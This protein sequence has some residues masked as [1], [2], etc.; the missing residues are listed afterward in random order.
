MSRVL[1]FFKAYQH[2]DAEETSI[3]L[4]E[5][6]ELY[7]SYQIFPKT[8]LAQLNSENYPK[9]SNLIHQM[10]E[11]SRVKTEGGRQYVENMNARTHA[12]YTKLIA[13]LKAFERDTLR[14][15]FNQHSSINL[16]ELQFVVFDLSKMQGLPQE[17]LNALLFNV[18][19]IMW[20]EVYRN[21]FINQDVLKDAEKRK[22]I[23]CVIDEAH[24]FFKSEQEGTMDF[25]S[26]MVR[27]AR[28][29]SAALWMA[30][31]SARDFYPTVSSNRGKFVD[32]M[33]SIFAL[34]PYKVLMKQ[35]QSDVRYLQELLPSFTDNE[36]AST[37]SFDRGQMLIEVAGEGKII[38]NRFIHP[39]YL[40]L[41]GGGR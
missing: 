5:L 13:I 18:L 4:G 28:K 30:S 21:R 26:L 25:I 31:Q 1:N 36:I 16:K 2:L 9:I 32:Q 12:Q 11:K 41:F 40:E 6:E 39:E 19:T 8:N 20:Q 27:Q 38:V 33:Q 17:A 29:N 3:I 34:V 23:I 10:S 24:R 35:D 14:R 15:I 7:A 37:L 22:Y